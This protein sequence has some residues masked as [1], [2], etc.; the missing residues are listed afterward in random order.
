MD[1]GIRHDEQ[2]SV[3]DHISK[4]PDDNSMGLPS[5]HQTTLLQ[6]ISEG[7]WERS[8]SLSIGYTL[9]RWTDA[10]G[11]RRASRFKCRKKQILDQVEP[12]ALEKLVKQQVKQ[13][14]VALIKSELGKIRIAG[15]SPVEHYL[16][17]SWLLSIVGRFYKN[18][19]DNTL[20]ESPPRIGEPSEVYERPCGQRILQPSF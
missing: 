7:S 3:L 9:L 16:G 4:I 8:C 13:T 20:E 19:S 17:H 5:K 1:G 14:K 6:F 10:E 11:K 15:A 12:E 2:I 18:W